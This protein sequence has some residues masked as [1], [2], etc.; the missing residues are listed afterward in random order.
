MMVCKQNGQKS[1]DYVSGISQW[2]RAGH[3]RVHSEDLQKHAF[4][5]RSEAGLATLVSIIT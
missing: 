1:K 4:I 5:H 3:P 2:Q